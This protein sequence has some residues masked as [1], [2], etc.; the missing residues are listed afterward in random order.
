MD[1]LAENQRPDRRARDLDGAN[2]EADTPHRKAL[3]RFSDAHA[4]GRACVEGA[5]GRLGLD[6]LRGLL[7][8]GDRAA[9]AGSTRVSRVRSVVPLVSCPG[10]RTLFFEVS[11]RGSTWASAGVGHIGSITQYPFI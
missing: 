8:D 9:V 10:F 5:V 11:R 2:M 7:A 4:A 6:V 1:E 3:G